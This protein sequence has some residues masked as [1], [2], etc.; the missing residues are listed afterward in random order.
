LSHELELALP[1]VVLEAGSWSGGRPLPGKRRAS[2]A[3]ARV[4]RLLAKVQLHRSAARRGTTV[5][6]RPGTIVFIASRHRLYRERT[7][8]SPREFFRLRRRRRYRLCRRRRRPRRDVRPRRANTHR[9]CTTGFLLRETRALPPRPMRLYAP[10]IYFKS[11]RS[12][13][14]S[15]F[16]ALSHSNSFFLSLSLSRN[17]VAHRAGL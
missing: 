8:S 11:I 3:I 12:Y 5:S 10:G 15:L 16:I 7:S 13:R 14:V 1:Q 4:D 6:R 17:L 2:V 9:K